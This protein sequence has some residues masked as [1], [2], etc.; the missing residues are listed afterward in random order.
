MTMGFVQ[1]HLIPHVRDLGFTYITNAG[2]QF[3]LALT[4]IVGAL[5]AG[6]FSDRIGRRRPL[7]MTFVWRG[8][9]YV[10]LACL[11]LWRTPLLLYAAVILMGLSWNSTSSLLA[12]TCVDL[13][14]RRAQAS[15]FGVVFGV[16]N[17]G[18]TLGAWLPGVL[19]DATGTYQYSLL[20]NVLIAW[21][22]SGVILGVQEWWHPAPAVVTPVR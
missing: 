8:L 1:V 14:G 7:S 9:A 19:Y 3:V 13:Y 22:A 4:S 5:L 2:A 12:T 11:T 18:G 17:W 15:V 20:L 21:V 10:V 6:S 16:M